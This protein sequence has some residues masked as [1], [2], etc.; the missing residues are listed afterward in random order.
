MSN[1]NLPAVITK[2]EKSFCYY[3]GSQGQRLVQSYVRAFGLT[4]YQDG[5]I[6]Y[7]AMELLEQPRVQDELNRLADARAR[8]ANT[9][10][11]AHIAGLEMIRDMALQDRE[12]TPATKAHELIGKCYGHYVNQNIN[13]NANVD[14]TDEQARQ[15]MRAIIEA[16]PA[17]ASH[18]RE[19]L[20]E[21]VVMDAD[22]TVSEEASVERGLTVSDDMSAGD[23]QDV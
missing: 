16:D 4:R 3:Y 8:I 14:L 5:A 11:D 18:L 15:Q 19:A 17:L 6:Y 23:R 1:N 20:P 9:S 7:K 12:Y 13:I 10:R 2:E 21:G 22:F